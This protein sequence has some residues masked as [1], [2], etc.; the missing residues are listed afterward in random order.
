MEGICSKCNYESDKNSRFFGVLLCEFCSH[1][2]P[3]NKEEFFNYISEKVNFRELETFRRE[4]KLGNSKQKIGMLKKAKE[5][6]IMTR[7]PFGYKILNNSLVKA[8]NFKVVE[9]IFLDFQNN[10][11]SLNKLSKK[12]GF[13]VNGI[14]KILKNFTYVGKIKFDGEIHE[15]IHEPI[16]SSTLFNHVQDKLERLGIK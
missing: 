3:Q 5:G 14:K 4:N 9:N 11:V 10:K 16:L 6:K 12:Y 15:G 8:E 13:S 1:F 2:A 7:A